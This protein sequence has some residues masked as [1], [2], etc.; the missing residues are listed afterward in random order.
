MIAVNGV[1]ARF[2]SEKKFP[3]IRRVVRTPKRW[4]RIVEIA[5]ENDFNLPESPNSM[6]LE[7]FLKTQ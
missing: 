3:S 2:L 7:E 4:E 6:A 1:T 5:K